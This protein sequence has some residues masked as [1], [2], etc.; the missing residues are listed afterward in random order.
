MTR[1]EIVVAI[2]VV[3]VVAKAIHDEHGREAGSW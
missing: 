2:A 1:D 3:A